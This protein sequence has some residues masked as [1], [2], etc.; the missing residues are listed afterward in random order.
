MPSP[1]PN[2]PL[3]PSA[4]CC[5]ATTAISRK[6]PSACSPTITAASP[7]ARRH[8]AGVS[9]ALVRRTAWATRLIATDPTLIATGSQ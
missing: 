4:Y 3:A 8:S 9:A 1:T 7:A 6:K 2:T 5:G